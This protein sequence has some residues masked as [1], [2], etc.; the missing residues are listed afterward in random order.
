MKQQQ[1]SFLQRLKAST[2]STISE[3]SAVQNLLQSRIIYR[4]ESEI[5][6]LKEDSMSCAWIPAIQLIPRSLLT[7][8]TT[9]VGQCLGKKQI[10][11]HHFLTSTFLHLVAADR[12]VLE[13]AGPLAPPCWNQ[14]YAVLQIQSDTEFTDTWVS[15]SKTFLHHQTYFSAKVNF[16][17]LSIENPLPMM[18]HCDEKS[19]IY[20]IQPTKLY[21]GWCTQTHTHSEEVH[22]I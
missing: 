18:V 16:E 15:C 22:R 13:Q 14:S 7:M 21:L 9:L 1:V 12:L 17:V 3:V 11:I 5:K 19:N 6:I 4:T 2:M 8:P 10:Q 20:H